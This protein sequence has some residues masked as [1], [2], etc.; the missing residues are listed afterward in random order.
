MKLFIN[1]EFAT[2]FQN[3]INYGNE[4]FGLT[5][6]RNMFWSWIGWFTA[7]YNLNP[8]QSF[9]ILDDDIIQMPVFLYVNSRAIISENFN[10]FI[11]LCHQHGICQYFQSLTFLSDLSTKEFQKP[12]VLTMEKLSAGFLVWIGSVVVACLVFFCELLVFKLLQN[13]N[14]GRKKLI[15]NPRTKPHYMCVRA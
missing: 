8:M 10:N 3:Q 14:S 5:V 4:S 13:R 2:I 12:Q 15:L 9:K 11:L 6:D 7:G 1:D